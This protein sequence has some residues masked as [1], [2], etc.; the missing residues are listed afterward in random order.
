LQWQPVK[1]TADK[2]LSWK[3]LRDRQLP[4]ALAVMLPIVVGR[5]FQMCWW[6]WCT[7]AKGTEP[8]NIPN[9]AN[10]HENEEVREIV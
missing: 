4:V 5:E 9:A 10:S 7:T 2:H 1:S 6:L 8:S 3:E